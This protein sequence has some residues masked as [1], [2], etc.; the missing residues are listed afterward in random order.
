MNDEPVD[1]LIIGA[2]ASGAAIAWSLADTRMRIVCLEQGEVMNPLNYPSTRRDGEARNQNDFSIS[3]NQ[4]KSAADYPIAE[5]DS[6]IKVANFNGVGGGT[7]LYAGHFP[8]FHPS[9]FKVKSLDGVA[10]DWP[11]DYSDLATHYAENDRMMGVAGLNGD[12]AYPSDNAERMPPLP[13]GKSG[14]ALAK[15]FNK[16]GW[17][18]WPSDTAIAT[19]PYDGRDKCINLGACITGCAQGA[20][21]STDITYW[22]HALRAGVELRTQCRVREITVDDAGMATGAAYVDPDGVEQFQAAHVVVMAC[23]GVG[24]PRILLNSKSD[25][26]PDGLANSS[27]LVGKNLM[28]H[29]YAS[30]QG[31]FEEELDGYKGPH[32]I[33]RSQEFYETDPDRDFV[34]GYTF[35]IQRGQGPVQ[36]ALTGLQR[37]KIPWGA[38]HH[39]AYRKLFN[40]IAGMVAVCED[41]PEEHNRVTLDPVLKDS[42]GIPAPKIS[43]TL[44]ENSR[45]MMDHAIVKAS[46]VLRAAGAVDILTQAPISYG[47]WHLMGTARMGTDPARS[48]VNEW[49]RSHDVKNLFVVDGSV[50]VT[51]AG[52]NPTRTIQA[53][54]LYVAEQMKQRLANLF[55]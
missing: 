45:K 7:V 41:L 55:D 38:G 35:E 22:P 4:R 24:T 5:D 2:G 46:E 42:D 13:L 8:R 52:V 20:K 10:D 43:Y 3:P 30:I 23:N 28:F 50:F 49:G 36:T 27:G 48:V 15:G 47:G 16:L 40:R 44:S 29:P 53:L 32:K 14:E 33:F 19:Q 37:D 11:I 9:D 6:P 54:A 51:S 31:I 18:W 1:V 17:H 39:A 34:R 26:F 12:P 25:A 21:A